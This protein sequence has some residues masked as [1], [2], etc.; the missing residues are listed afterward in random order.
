MLDG[1]AFAHTLNQTLA[2]YVY[3]PGG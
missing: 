3:Q 1:C 2:G